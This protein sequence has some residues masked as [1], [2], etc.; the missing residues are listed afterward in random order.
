MASL[1]SSR[2]HRC[3]LAILSPWQTSDTSKVGLEL[4]WNLSNDNQYTIHYSIMF[5]VCYRHYFP[6]FFIFSILKWIMLKVGKVR[7]FHDISNKNLLKCNKIRRY[8]NI[9]YKIEVEQNNGIFFIKLKYH[10]PFFSLVKQ[11][12]HHK[13]HLQ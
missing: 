8:T 6:T 5:S 13:L 10:T 4:A 1:I 7:M 3:K 11:P 2:N 9:Q 12:L